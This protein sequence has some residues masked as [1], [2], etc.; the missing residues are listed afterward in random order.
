LFL[1]FFFLK[2]FSQ[3]WELNQGIFIK[4]SMKS[5]APVTQVCNPSYL[6]G[7]DQEDYGSSQPGEVVPETLS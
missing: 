3:Y 6:E 7:R 4:I 5:W 1:S 2:N